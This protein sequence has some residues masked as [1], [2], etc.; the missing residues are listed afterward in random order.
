MSFLT[1]AIRKSTLML[2]GQRDFSR[3]AQDLSHRQESLWLAKHSSSHPARHVTLAFVLVSFTLEHYFTFL[4]DHLSDHLCCSLHTETHPATIH[5]MCLSALWLSR[6]RLQVTS[7]KVSLKRAPLHRSNRRSTTD[8]ARRRRPT[9]L[10]LDDEQIR[11]MLA[12][13]LYLQE[14]EASD[15]EFITHSEKSVSSSSR[16]RASGRETCR[17]VLTQ[18]KVQSRNTFRQRR[19]FLRTSISSRRKRNP[20]QILRSRRCCEI[21]SRRTKRSSTR[22]SKI[23]NLEARV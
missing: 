3:M 11:N 7:P 15:Y 16:F 4:S 19:H 21:S 2:P 8:R 6:T 13:P 17:S 14:R 10:D 20:I 12:S 22:R 23:S 18:K 5:R 9:Q 1:Q